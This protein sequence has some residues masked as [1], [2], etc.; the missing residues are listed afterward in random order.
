MPE[1]TVLYAMT[2]LVTVGLAVWVVVVLRVAKEPWA[3]PASGGAAAPDVEAEARHDEADRPAE[4]G[5][6]SGD[7]SDGA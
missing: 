7:D 5:K 2:A 4:G 1:P 6:G 3:R